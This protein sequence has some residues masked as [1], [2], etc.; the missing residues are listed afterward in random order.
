MNRAAAV[1]DE[2]VVQMHLALD[3]AGEE[4][5]HGAYTF[6]CQYAREHD[7]FSGENVSDAHIAEGLPQPTNLRAWGGLYQRAQREGVIEWLD[8]NGKSWRR[9]S[10]CPRYR[11]LVFQIGRAA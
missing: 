11:S 6:L 9:C 2:R 3:A 1:R 4:W 5:K 7:V 10:P 8:N